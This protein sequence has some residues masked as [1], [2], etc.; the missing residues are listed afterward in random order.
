MLMR[1][2]IKM[3]NFSLQQVAVLRVF[4]QRCVLSL[5]SHQ[6]HGDEFAAALGIGNALVVGGPLKG[7]LLHMLRN[8]VLFEFPYKLL[9]INLNVERFVSLKHLFDLVRVKRTIHELVDFDLLDHAIAM[10]EVLGLVVH[11]DVDF[12]L[13]LLIMSLP[14]CVHLNNLISADKLNFVYGRPSV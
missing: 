3:Q 13:L 11:V 5:S 8:V 2:L 12:F 14:S 1:T 7:E 6:L 10:L 9:P 4:L